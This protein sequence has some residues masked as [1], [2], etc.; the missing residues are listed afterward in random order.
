M[1]TLSQWDCY[2][3]RLNFSY[4]KSSASLHVIEK[5]QTYVLTTLFLFD[6]LVFCLFDVFFRRCSFRF[7]DFLHIVKCKYNCCVD[8]Y[9]WIIVTYIKKDKDCT[10][11]LSATLSFWRLHFLH[12]T[13]L[14]RKML[15]YVVREHIFFSFAVFINRFS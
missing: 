13:K 2:L 12:I 3:Q 7:Q 10:F 11:F 6:C 4:D 8:N 9:I 14:K 5:S 15:S 1:Y